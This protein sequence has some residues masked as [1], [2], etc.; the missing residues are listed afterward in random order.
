MGAVHSM[1]SRQ[2]AHKCT[3]TGLSEPAS[4]HSGLPFPARQSAVESAGALH[5]RGYTTEDE[6]E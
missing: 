4:A 3:G 2:M 6:N 1:R 5:E